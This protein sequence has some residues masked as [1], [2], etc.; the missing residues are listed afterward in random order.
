MPLIFEKEVNGASL[1]V[2]HIVETEACLRK[3]CRAV[4]DDILIV[5]SFLNESRRKQWLACRAMLGQM[6]RLGSVKV[7]YDEHG[8][9]SLD[10]F[11]GQISFSH[12]REYAAVMINVNGPAGIDI[13]K[14]SPRIERV[15]E[16]FL[17]D[18][19][20]EN[21]RMMEEREEKRNGGREEKRDEEREEKRD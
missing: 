21:I 17:Q 20:L 9:P 8:K 6:L 2:W 16:R 4:P 19:E 11:R 13:E 5:D 1:G 14:I 15:A 18:G 10:G 3:V 7:C 12:T